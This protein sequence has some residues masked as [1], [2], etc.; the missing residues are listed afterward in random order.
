MDADG[1]ERLSG[2]RAAGRDTTVRV[3][4]AT[5]LGGAF[6]RLTFGA[7][8]RATAC[9]RLADRADVFGRF[10][11]D[12]RFGAAR[13]AVFRAAAPF[14]D[15]FRAVVLRAAERRRPAGPDPRRVVRAAFRLAIDRP[16][17]SLSRTP[18]YLDSYR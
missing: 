17:Q 1:R 3:G 13:L 18:A 2:A 5:A 7:T 14:R 9:G 15:V 8:L 10:A 11:A 12:F 16:F 6:L 4:R